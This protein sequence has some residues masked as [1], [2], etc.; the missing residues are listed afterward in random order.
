MPSESSK[1]QFLEVAFM[2]LSLILGLQ[3]H[4]HCRRMSWTQVFFFWHFSPGKKKCACRRESE[5]E[6]VRALELMDSD[7]LWKDH[8]F[9]RVGPDA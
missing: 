7:D 4:P 3:L 2:S 5:C 1:F 9:R 6:G 8:R